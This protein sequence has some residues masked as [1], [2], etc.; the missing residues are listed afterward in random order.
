MATEKIPAFLREKMSKLEDAFIDKAENGINSGLTFDQAFSDKEADNINYRLSGEWR[1]RYESMVDRAY[2]VTK[3]GKKWS[4][5]SV[6]QEIKDAREAEVQH[7]QDEAFFESNR[8]EF[9]EKAAKCKRFSDTGYSSDLEP[10]FRRAQKELFGYQPGDE[11]TPAYDP[12][13]AGFGG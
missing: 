11:A 4:A 12:F 13:L 6:R 5:D 1:K 8:R 9:L 2:P 3:Y 7:E 10:F